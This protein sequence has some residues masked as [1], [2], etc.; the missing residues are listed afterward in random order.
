MRDVNHVNLVG[1][2]TKDPEL[3]GSRCDLTLA[4]DES[5]CRVAVSGE[6]G[7]QIAEHVHVN[8]RI[9]VSGRLFSG[10]GYNAVIAE[11]VFLIQ[12]C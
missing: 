11:N 2:V 6:Q 8:D 10:R 1:R 9:A 4:F 3:S 5:V 7:K 12:K